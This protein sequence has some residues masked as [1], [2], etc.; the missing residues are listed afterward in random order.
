VKG[1]KRKVKKVRKVRKVGSE[2]VCVMNGTRNSSKK[3]LG[4]KDPARHKST[5]GMA[6]SGK[7]NVNPSQR[8]SA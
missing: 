8:L 3:K 7:L 1:K 2:F 5:V 6:V 4:K